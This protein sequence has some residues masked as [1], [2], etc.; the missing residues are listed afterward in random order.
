MTRFP[1]TQPRITFDFF[2]V[3]MVAG[4]GGGSSAHNPFM[5]P[6]TATIG[7]VSAQVYK[8]KISL[9]PMASPS[10]LEADEAPARKTSLFDSFRPRSK[11]DA[12]RKL[13]HRRVP[14]VSDV[15]CLLTLS[16]RVRRLLNIPFVHKSQLIVWK[17]SKPKIV[18]F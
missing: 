9:P 6:R 14:I 17:L 4:G 13:N 8:K 15:S 5:R 7:S 2:I 1:V 10:Q 18:A 3:T 12:A 11:S 16:S